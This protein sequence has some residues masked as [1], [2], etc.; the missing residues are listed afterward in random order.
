MNTLERGP[1]LWPFIRRA[2][3]LFRASAPL[4]PCVEYVLLFSTAVCVCGAEIPKAPVPKSPYIAVVYRYADTMLEKGRFAQMA[5]DV[6]WQDN[7][8][9]RASMQTGHYETITG[10]DSLALA[11]LDVHAASYGLK[12]R[13]PSN[14]IDR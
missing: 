4:R 1:I 8:L 10:C 11:L 7:P 5:V 12:T 3:S 14:T 6:F 2:V 9:P 13:I